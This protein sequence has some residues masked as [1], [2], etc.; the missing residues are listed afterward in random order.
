V[1]GVD[2]GIQVFGKRRRKKEN[3]CIKTLFLKPR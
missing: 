2:R 3:L 1:V